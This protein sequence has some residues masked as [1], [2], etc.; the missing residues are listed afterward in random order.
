[1]FPEG[2]VVRIQFEDVY[3]GEDLD[4]TNDNSAG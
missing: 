1:L 4:F 2:S 3:E